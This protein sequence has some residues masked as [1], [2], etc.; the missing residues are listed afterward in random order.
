MDVKKVMDEV[1]L[2][3]GIRIDENDPLIVLLAL[4]EVVLKDIADKCLHIMSAQNE[5]SIGKAVNESLNGFKLKRSDINNSNAFDIA[6]TKLEHKASQKMLDACRLVIVQ[7]FT[8]K[9]AATNCS[10]DH[11][12]VQTRV[13]SIEK[14]MQVNQSAETKITT[15]SEY[16]ERI[17]IGEYYVN[18]S[19]IEYAQFFGFFLLGLILMYFLKY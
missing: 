13:K 3:T 18:K 14:L 8:V 9:A 2:K 7:G 15:I 19:I 10:V 17:R 4:N 6:I 1:Y 16:S 5:I 12:L 11:T